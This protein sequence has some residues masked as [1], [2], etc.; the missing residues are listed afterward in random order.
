MYLDADASWANLVPK[1]PFFCNRGKLFVPEKSCARF[2]MTLSKFP[3]KYSANSA[4]LE[5]SCETFILSLIFFSRTVYKTFLL[6]FFCP[7]M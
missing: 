5:P 6:A 1:L 4:T 3:C 2:T 7:S